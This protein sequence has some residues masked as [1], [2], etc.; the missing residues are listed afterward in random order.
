MTDD[1]KL[2]KLIEIESSAWEQVVVEDI[3]IGVPG[4]PR[5]QL[6]IIER[7]QRIRANIEIGVPKHTQFIGRREQ[8][9]IFASTPSGGVQE[10]KDGEWVECHASFNIANVDNTE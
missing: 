1:E 9:S 3:S 7:C 10:F 4:L 8:R 2:A 6:E 5:Y